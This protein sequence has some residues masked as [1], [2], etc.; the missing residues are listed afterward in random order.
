MSS[1]ARRFRVSGW[2]HSY[3][4]NPNYVKPNLEGVDV[5]NLS[6]EQ[7]AAILGDAPAE[8]VV[9]PT[10]FHVSLLSLSMDGVEV[11]YGKVVV[12]LDT[13]DALTSENYAKIRRWLIERNLLSDGGALDAASDVDPLEV[14]KSLRWE[15][16]AGIRDGMEAKGFPYLGHWFDSDE[17][18]VARINTT[19]QA[20]MAAAI[21]GQDFVTEWTTADNYVVPM[22]RDEIIGM[23]VAFATYAASL[24][25]K[26]RSLRQRINDAKS[27]SEVNACIWE[28]VENKEDA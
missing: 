1:I 15:V 5:E 20:A 11:E 16:V 10:Y 3:K 7:L 12:K 25:E 19:A 8:I 13:V 28:G 4:E 21:A 23:P 2:T 9:A 26:A 14:A 24:H 17:R 22:T 6:Q 18:S 27:I